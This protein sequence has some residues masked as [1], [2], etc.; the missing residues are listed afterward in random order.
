MLAQAAGV[1]ANVVGGCG[2]RR[3]GEV[4][5]HIRRERKRERDNGK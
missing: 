1:Q 5:Q 3:G 2:E 4:M